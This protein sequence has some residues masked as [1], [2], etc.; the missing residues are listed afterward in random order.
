MSTLYF[1]FTS[2]QD[3]ISLMKKNKT[4]LVSMSG[5]V[6]SLVA[7]YVLKKQGYEIT[8]AI[9][10]I[11]SLDGESYSL[12]GT[13]H[14]N[15]EDVVKKYCDQLNIPYV[16]IDGTEYYNE[17]IVAKLIAARLSG[18]T[19]VPC[20]YC[21]QIRIELLISKADEL[22]MKFVATG[23]LAQVTKSL[24]A[25]S[26]IISQALDLSND[27]SYF[28]TGLDNLKLERMLLPLGKLAL[29]EIVKI[30]KTLIGKKAEGSVKEICLTD[31][32]L[33]PRFIESHVLEKLRPGGKVVGYPGNVPLGEHGGLYQYKLGQKQIRSPGNKIDPFFEIVELNPDKNEIKVAKNWKH[34]LKYLVLRNFIPYLDL[35]L[36]KP[37]H[38][39]VSFDLSDTQL[40][41]ILY[42]NNNDMAHV[43]FAKPMEIF[44]E[45]GTHVVFYLNRKVIGSGTVHACHKEGPALPE[46][47]KL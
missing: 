20:V 25:N 1:Y 44:L 39:Q 34:E 28:L 37:I 7:A 47:F 46:L 36:S 42:L 30:G 43:E 9:V 29:T 18:E 17:F 13:C 8:G 3:I 32:D 40:A 31:E 4:V 16:E 27:Q 22:G 10:Q 23:H 45:R 35:D 15:D 24:T 11:P 19:F 26:Y 41:V 38:C 33:L 12:R 5:G 6:K 2:T 14:Q 21:N